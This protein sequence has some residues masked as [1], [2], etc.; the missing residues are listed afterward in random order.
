VAQ[1]SLCEGS[2]G[3]RN[4]LGARQ[5]GKGRCKSERGR[6]RDRDRDGGRGLVARLKL[7]RMAAKDR[8]RRSMQGRCARPPRL[9]VRTGLQRD[10]KRMP[11]IGRGEESDCD[12][13]AK[14][15]LNL[16]EHRRPCGRSVHSL[17]LALRTTPSNVNNMLPVT[18]AYVFKGPTSRIYHGH[19]RYGR[20]SFI[21]VILSRTCSN[22][23]SIL[24]LSS[25]IVADFI[26][27]YCL[28]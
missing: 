10:E 8:P 21:Q 25:P 26:V 11:A 5:Y 12:Q 6:D 18:H 9:Q 4:T 2:E 24:S 16:P 27:F 13:R 7:V 23:Q 15:M 3:G 20:G 1:S 22:S 19:L 17:A 14:E 28:S